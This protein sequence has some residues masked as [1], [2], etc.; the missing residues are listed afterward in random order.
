MCTRGNLAPAHDSRGRALL[1]RGGESAAAAASRSRVCVMC[2]REESLLAWIR[3]R[4]RQRRTDGRTSDGRRL[5][6]VSFGVRSRPPREEGVNERIG[7]LEP[8]VY[9]S[10]H[11][12]LLRECSRGN[13]ALC[14]AAERVNNEAGI[15]A[16]V[17]PFRGLRL[18]RQSRAR[19]RV[20][21]HIV[22]LARCAAPRPFTFIVAYSVARS[23]FYVALPSSVVLPLSLSIGGGRKRPAAV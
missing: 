12:R 15:F 4:G 17:S 18:I 2:Q 7:C 16:A 13:A 23:V 14:S 5:R 20:E 1:W 6:S 10:L 8:K 3:K 9:C 11:T 22:A 21:P 19:A